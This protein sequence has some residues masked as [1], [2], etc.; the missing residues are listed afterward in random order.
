ML[1]YRRENYFMKK[2][3]KT[4]V[5]KLFSLIFAVMML[6]SFA[7]CGKKDKDDPNG[8]TLNEYIGATPDKWNAHTWETSG[9]RYIPGYTEIGFVDIAYDPQTGGWK[10]AYE[11]ADAM[12]D[13]TADFA[14]K[15]KWGIEEGQTGRVWKI[16]LNQAAKWADGTPINADT[17][18]YAMQQLLNPE[19]KNYRA[20]SY[21]SDDIAIVGAYDYFYSGSTSKV[22]NYKGE[23]TY[24]YPYETWVLGDD[25]VYTGED[26]TKLYFGLNDV[27]AYLQGESLTSYKDYMTEAQCGI[28]AY[29]LLA[30]KA[31]DK[32]YVPVTD[33]TKDILFG[34]TSAPV[35]GKETEDLL[36]AYVLYDFTFP[37]F[38][39]EG[40]GLV[41]VD[42]YTLYYICAEPISQ[43]NFYVNMTSIWLVYE[44][45]YEAGKSKVG[46]LV[47]TNYG[48]A[49]NN[50]MSYGPYKLVS[51]E[52]DKQ[53]VFE[54]NEN[55]Y[56]Y[57]DGKHEGQYQTD[58]IRCA[59]VSDHNTQLELFE[60]GKLDSVELSSD[61]MNE[62]R[63]SDNLLKVP[64]T[65]TFRYFFV[66]DKEVLK[67]LSE[68][69]SS[70]SKS[71][72]KVILAYD[73]FRHAMSLAID[74]ADY[75]LKGTAG[76]DAAF[77]LINSLYYYDIEHD[78]DSV[79]RKSDEA[80]Q[81]ICDIYD[82]KYGEG[83]K[84]ATLD[85]AY[86]SVTGY[87]VDKAR[88][89]FQK[90]WDEAYAAGDVKDG[91]VFEFTCPVVKKELTAEDMTQQN[92]I[93][94]YIDAAIAGTPFEGKVTI[95]YTTNEDRY[96][97][98]G[99]GRIE[100]ARGA[101]GGGAFY[102]YSMIR[103]YVDPSYT[104]IHERCGFDPTQETMSITADF[105]GNGTEETLK[106]SYYNWGASINPG[107]K[108]N[109]ADGKLKLKILA[110]IE[111]NLIEQYHFIILSSENLVTIYSDKI[112]YGT[113]QYDVMYEFGGIRWLT[114]NYNNGEW[115]QYV[116]D[117]GGTLNY[118]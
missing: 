116:K 92:L 10:W 52:K 15:E 54:K 42:D 5:I 45:L 88:E 97:A 48:T 58:K 7:S 103:C 57:T 95:T 70:D 90:A 73:D 13:V 59:I 65:Y 93:Q 69:A 118:K 75:V 28:N 19:M 94:G 16:S 50:Y 26:G 47:A 63:H 82:V 20:N 18:I 41:K 85:E 87:D 113:T 74:R 62:Y 37:V 84:Y 49:V 24:V 81:V 89:L 21:Y 11:M 78:P 9:D 4:G 12:E 25:G 17:Y 44:K 22:Q 106:D 29:D 40:V 108:Y 33:E 1:I 27:L 6:I 61:D 117:N 86:E 64:Q 100:M 30:A 109:L 56:G 105:D 36:A 80:K 35:W 77:G 67:T 34:F 115:E 39:W 76:H 91:D 38:D 32:G 99:E 60:T 51:F 96:A 55:W 114:Y 101:W 46:D 83:E 79:Y 110:A 14:D 3:G 111:K 66:T 43:F 68:N 112:K 98:V 53:I 2:N 104:E 102:P 107:G 72:N 31:D 23:N 8:Y 71:V